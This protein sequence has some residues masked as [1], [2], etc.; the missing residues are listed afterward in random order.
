[1][2]YIKSQYRFRSRYM[3]QLVNLLNSF[4]FTNPMQI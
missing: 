1:M 2:E 3:I 4:N